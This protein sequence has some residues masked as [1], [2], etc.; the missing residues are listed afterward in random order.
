MVG[1]AA[2]F[3]AALKH[4]IPKRKDQIA[5]FHHLKVEKK[6]NV[7]KNGEISLVV[8]VGQPACLF[9]TT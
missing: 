3:P 4:S 8:C 5:Q 7:M 9:S 6:G 1:W 2:A